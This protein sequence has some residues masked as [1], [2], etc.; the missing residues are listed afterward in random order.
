MTA[1]RARWLTAGGLVVAA[2]GVAV[3]ATHLLTERDRCWDAMVPAY[4]PPRAIADLVRR[5]P[6][7]RLLIVNPAS[8]P[9]DRPSEPYRRAIAAARQ[10]GS[11]VL[12]YVRTGYGDREAAAVERDIDRYR[13]WYG[14]DG[15]FL[16]ESS[17]S[18]A[19]LPYYRA[20]GRYAR[21]SGLRLVAL[22]PGVTPERGY[23]TIADVVVTFEGPASGYREA[24][25]AAPAWLSQISPRRIAHLVYDAT[26]AQAASVLA[27]RSGAG[28]VYV[29]GGR[30]PN[31]WRSPSTYPPSQRR[32]SADC[33]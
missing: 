29:T 24:L 3:I 25:R 18:A 13:S 20:L 27:T 12:G 8:G 15:I 17:P 22:N 33:R 4:F 9:G 23:F 21:R 19:Q 16:D 14:V 1:R 10:V 32:T 6:P 11:G 2:A 5:S 28:N 30:P 26:P 7:P 31:P